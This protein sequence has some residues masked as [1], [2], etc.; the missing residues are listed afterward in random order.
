MFRAAC[1]TNLLLYKVTYNVLNVKL[2]FSMKWFFNAISFQVMAL[3]NFPFFPLLVKIPWLL[4]KE[5]RGLPLTSPQIPFPLL[6]VNC[7]DFLGKV[8]E[9]FPVAFSRVL[10]SEFS[11]LDWLFLKAS[12]FSLPCYLTYNLPITISGST[13]ITITLTAHDTSKSIKCYPTDTNRVEHCCIHSK[14]QHLKF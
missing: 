14:R 7:H 11:C 1:R 8:M 3:Y 5:L 2:V 10:I 6:F 13:S 12:K 9:W 4:G